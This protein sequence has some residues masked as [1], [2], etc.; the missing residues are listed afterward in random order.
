MTR[1]S[2]GT[3]T[4]RALGIL[5]TPDPTVASCI[6]EEDA[7]LQ[8]M[9]LGDVTNLSNGTRLSASTVDDGLSGV[10][11]VASS[12]GTDSDEHAESEAEKAS[13]SKQSGQRNESNSAPLPVSTRKRHKHMDVDSTEPSGDEVVST[14]DANR[15]N[16]TQVGIADGFRTTSVN[17]S[18]RLVDPEVAGANTGASRESSIKN[19]KVDKIRPL[20]LNKN[21]AKT[22]PSLPKT[23]MSPASL[24]PHSRKPSTASTANVPLQNLREDEE[25]LSSKPRC[26][27]CRKSKK[28]CDR[29]RPCQRCKDAGIGLEG[30]I[31]EDETNGRKGRFGRHMG[32][33]VK[34]GSRMPVQGVESQTPPESVEAVAGGGAGEKGKKRKR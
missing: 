34:K 13:P 3:P 5:P 9:R 8:L 25:D 20:A 28:G 14:S 22:A 10:A 6:S 27:R 33:V 32:V 21:K 19:S 26:Q 1:R 4:G 30:C 12:D 17:A 7:A 23:P 31:S 24:P 29:Q 11:D 15:L 18:E 2:A 16:R